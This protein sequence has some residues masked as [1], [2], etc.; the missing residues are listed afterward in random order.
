MKHLLFV[1]RLYV[2]LLGR[3]A[4]CRVAGALVTA[5]AAVLRLSKRVAAPAP[6]T[7]SHFTTF[8]AE[9]LLPAT[10]FIPSELKASVLFPAEPQRPDPLTVAEL[11]ENADRWNRPVFALRVPGFLIQIS[12][13]ND[14]LEKATS[15]AGDEGDPQ[16]GGRLRPFFARGSSCAVQ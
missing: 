13:L 15:R 2:A 12:K 10:T 9:T 11:L 16:P 5:S 8:S 1:L 6:P 14:L 4:R 7:G 3:S